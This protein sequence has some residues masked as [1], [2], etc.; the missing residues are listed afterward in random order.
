MTAM[1]W[2]L[3]LKRYER[4][5]P[6]AKP[7]YFYAYYRNPKIT[8][9]KA[10]CGFCKNGKGMQHN[11]LGNATGRWRGGYISVELALE[12]ANSISHELGVEPEYCK[13]CFPDRIAV[14]LN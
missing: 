14:D 11:K 9:H 10:E 13:R 12:A 3:Y 2:Y 7:F 4:M 1:S 5:T 6:T 8:L